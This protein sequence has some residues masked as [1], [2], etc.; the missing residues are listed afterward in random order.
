MQWL[1]HL[2]VIDWDPPSHSEAFDIL[3]SPPLLSVRRRKSSRYIPTIHP[4]DN[5]KPSI[6]TTYSFAPIAPRLTS[7]QFRTF[8]SDSGQSIHSLLSLTSEPPVPE[9]ALSYSISASAALSALGP[10]MTLDAYW[11]L[12]KQCTSFRERYFE[13]W[14]TVT[15]S[16]TT[17]AATASTT[18]TGVDAVIMPVAPSASVKKGEGKYFGYTGVGNVLDAS[19]I[20]VPAG[21]VDKVRDGKKERDM[22]G[23]GDMDREIWESCEFPPFL[24]RLVGW[25]SVRWRA[26]E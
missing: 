9:L 14:N 5:F 21:T 25:S 7:R 19:V 24:L 18:T 4:S 12:Q 8:T 6:S 10:P 13:Y 1:I 20:T 11:D 3:V 26:V 2:Q 16:T 23:V 15:A 17:A 22:E